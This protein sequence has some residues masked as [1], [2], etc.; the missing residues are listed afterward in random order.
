M[1]KKIR[2]IIIIALGVFG[3]PCDSLILHVPGSLRGKMQECF[4]K[5]CDNLTIFATEKNLEFLSIASQ[6]ISQVLLITATEDKNLYCLLRKY[7]R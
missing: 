7:H 1:G 6:V 5:A 3:S 2:A 4:H